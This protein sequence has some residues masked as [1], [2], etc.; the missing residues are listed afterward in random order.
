MSVHEQTDDSARIFQ[1]RRCAGIVF[2]GD[3]DAPAVRRIFGYLA[4]A[5]YEVKF[6]GGTHRSRIVPFDSVTQ[7]CRPP[8]SVVGRATRYFSRTMNLAA[9]TMPLSQ[10]ARD[11]LNRWL[12]G[13]VVPSDFACEVLVVIDALV[14]PA[15]LD[16]PRRHRP[17]LWWHLRDHPVKT[18]QRNVVTRILEEPI[19]RRTMARLGRVPDLVTTVSTGIASDL[20][21]EF[22]MAS[23]VILN[24]PDGLQ[25]S[26]HPRPSR[27]QEIRIVHHARFE[28][29]RRPWVLVSALCRLPATYRSDLYFLSSTPIL[30]I[31]RALTARRPHVQVHGPLDEVPGHRVL[32]EYD[33]GLVAFPTTVP[34]LRYALPNKLFQ[35]LEA[36]LGLVG[37]ETTAAG[38]LIRQHGLG[39][40]AEAYDARSICAAISRLDRQELSR[41][42]GNVQ[43]TAQRLVSDERS[44]V[45]ELLDQLMEK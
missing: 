6:F 24:V 25:G 30:I 39:E 34:N 40:L 15:I 2:H 29:N 41:L 22:G 26:G 45:G 17:K 37:V 32:S 13:F 36:G 19:R 11:R 23:K 33:V 44:R 7:I 8:K 4:E 42:Q 14:A 9:Q 3:A 12:G 10:V 21:R 5:G 28:F 18:S 43:G 27:Q 35:Y 16:R 20:N 31:L 38:D 1:A